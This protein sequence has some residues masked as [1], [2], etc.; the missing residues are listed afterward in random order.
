MSEPRGENLSVGTNGASD[1]TG[2][3][4]GRI[5]A[6]MRSGLDR[7]MDV[8]AERVFAEPV[9]V[10]ERVVIVGVRCHQKTTF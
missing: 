4:D 6:T 1:A 7:L 2:A 8:S 3:D 9:R 10:G 5:R